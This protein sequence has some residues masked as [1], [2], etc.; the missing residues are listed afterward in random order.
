MKVLISH[1]SRR[2]EQYSDVLVLGFYLFFLMPPA[3][4]QLN[5]VIKLLVKARLL[6]EQTDKGKQPVPVIHHTAQRKG[7]G[8]FRLCMVLAGIFFVTA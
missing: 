4:F 1:H 3:Q 2:F 6:R 8:D 5:P 7:T